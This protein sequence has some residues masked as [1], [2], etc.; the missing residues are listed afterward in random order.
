MVTAFT[1][2]PYKVSKVSEFMKSAHSSYSLV[3]FHDFCTN[4]EAITCSTACEGRI[5]CYKMIYKIFVLY[6]IC[7]NTGMG[8]RIDWLCVCVCVCVC[9]CVRLRARQCVYRCTQKRPS[10][11]QKRQ[12]HTQKQNLLETVAKYNG[13]FGMKKTKYFGIQ[14]GISLLSIISN[15]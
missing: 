15:N 6:L 10:K 14:P 1:Y 7:A 3:T 11:C 9:A 2:S 12:S 13:Q 4:L 8:T 5:T